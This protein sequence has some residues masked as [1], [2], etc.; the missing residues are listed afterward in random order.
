MYTI[1][2][3]EEFASNYEAYVNQ[4]ASENILDFLSQD[5]S[6]SFLKSID[7]DKW[8]HSYAEGKW[9]IKE[10]IGHLIDTER[11][12]TYRALRIARKDKTPILG[13]EQDDYVANDQIASRTPASLIS[14]FDSVRK[15]TYSL[16]G[17]FN[18]DQISSVGTASDKSIT[19][20][21]LAYLIIGHQKHH[22]AIIKERYL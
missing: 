22:F 11:I 8:D 20:N 9:T 7:D 13:F 2:T 4:A 17:N 16:F 6:S 19:V 15:A 18:S 12:F 5:T 3:P 1:P 10:I 21:A 14:E